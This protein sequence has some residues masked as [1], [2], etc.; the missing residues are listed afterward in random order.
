MKRLLSLLL[1]TLIVPLFGQTNKASLSSDSAFYQAIAKSL[2]FPAVAQREGRSIKVYVEFTVTKQGEYRDVSI[3]NAGPVTEP[4]HQEID[5]LWPLLPKPRPEFAG[6][7]VI[8]LLFMLGEGGP[9]HVKVIANQND[10][11]AK[12]GT[13]MLLEAVSVTGWIVCELRRPLT[14]DVPARTLKWSPR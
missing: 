14:T 8:P 12:L 1:A 6:N 3:V 10:E 2:R 11:P 9:H 5:R 7:Y 13:F 4:I